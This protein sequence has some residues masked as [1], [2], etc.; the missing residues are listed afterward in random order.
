MELLRSEYAV[1]QRIFEME[2]LL[3]VRGQVDHGLGEGFY[4]MSQD[5]YRRQFQQELGWDPYPGTLN[6]KLEGREAAKLEVLRKGGG[7][8]IEGFTSG[9]RSFGGATC[10]F[11]TLQDVAC[12]VIIP[13]RSHYDDVLEVISPHQ[14]RKELGL[15]D[16]E[17][18]EV[19]V[20]L[21]T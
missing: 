9:K 21:E 12:A 3:E 1:Y 2:G 5:G 13:I 18:V 11:A 16:G 20:H 17:M 6:L 15:K 4:Y 19:L 8:P 7:I 10:F 14:L